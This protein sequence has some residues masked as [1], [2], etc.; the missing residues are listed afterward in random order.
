MKS[1]TKNYVSNS[2]N[3]R[4]LVGIG[5]KC[6]TY[7]LVIFAFLLTALPGWAQNVVQESV[8]IPN[9][10]DTGLNYKLYSDNTATLLGATSNEISA[11][12]IPAIVTY[13]K[14]EYKV[15]KIGDDAFEVYPYLK[16]ISGGEN[17]TE[18]RN[19]AFTLCS[20]LT[21]GIVFNNVT[22][23]GSPVNPRV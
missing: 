17:I 4:V 18:I 15:T 3:L 21:G 23:I 7:L 14:Q 13:E 2:L 10:D 16:S 1:T 8:A 12:N 20:A 9:T 11:L 6:R 5:E 19:N 22:N